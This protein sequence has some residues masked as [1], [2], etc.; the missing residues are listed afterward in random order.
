MADNESRHLVKNTKPL[1]V[2]WVWLFVIIVAAA[3][4]FS[5]GYTHYVGRRMA[6]VHGPLIDAAME[7]KLQATTAH[8]WFEEAISGDRTVDVNATLEHLAEADWYARAMLEGGTSTE[9]MFVPMFD[10]RMREYIADVR[11]KLAEFREVALERWKAKASAGIG[12]EIDQRFDSIFKELIERTDIVETDLQRA[13]SEDMR[14]F[15]VLQMV[16]M[17]GCGLVTVVAGVAF[18]RLV[19]RHIRDEQKLSAANRQLDAANQ[20]LE[21]SNQQLSANEQQLRAANEQLEAANQQ[22]MSSEQQLK[23]SN[24]QL[25][26]NEQQLRAANEQLEATNQQLRASQE[27]ISALAKFPAENP[28][29]IMRVTKDGTVIYA[30]EASE[31]LLSQWSCEVGSALPQ[32]WR[33]FLRDVFNSGRSRESDVDYECCSMSL[34]FAPI[35]DLGYVNI[36]GLDITERKGAQ[37]ALLAGNQQLETANQQLVSTE[38]QLKASNQQFEAANQQLVSSEEQLKRANSELA[39]SEQ[40]YR[41]VYNTAPLAFVLWDRDCLVTDWNDQA[42]AFFGWERAEV[43]GRNFFEF[44]IPEESRPQIEGIVENLLRGELPS[45]SVNKNLTKSGRMVLCEWN[46]TICYDEAGEVV[47]VISLALDITARKEAEEQL[48]RTRADLEHTAR[49]ITAGEM[50][51][52]LAHEINQPLCAILNYANACLRGV[53]TGEFNQA[54]ITDVLDEI[55]SQADRAGE[56]IR[57]LRRLVSKRE[58]KQLSV[59]VN[60]IVQ[61]VVD[62]EQAEAY[63]N[64]IVVVTELAEDLQPILADNIQIEQ[65]I[66]NLVRNAFEA[67]ADTPPEKRRVTIRTG[68]AESGTIEVVVCDTGGG[69]SEEAADHM[70]DSF[71]STKDDGLGV[72]LS[73]CRSIVEAHGGRISAESNQDG[74]ATFRFTLP[75]KGEKNG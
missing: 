33:R 27:E 12:T 20:Q 14:R 2:Y 17:V 25:S 61:E 53:K 59:N 24:Q 63:H 46:N 42:E 66:L 56:I 34:T 5:V 38:Q 75:R 51:S 4:M 13:I 3:A 44:L 57:R 16:L 72:G 21:A 43:L 50:A 68:T 10:T 48:R 15:D 22:L 40:R 52:G 47:G 36:Y 70:F 1:S 65:L 9:R 55:A 31:C 45:H 71:Y 11:R 6:E 74:G 58:P 49:L 39:A 18:T 19:Q 37:K 69:L 41:N 28:N 29:L 7:I 67:M 73:L 62:L 30:N 26:A 64:S 23:A 54:K 60:E 32:E 8:L 35:T